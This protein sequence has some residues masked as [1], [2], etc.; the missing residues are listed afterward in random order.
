MMVEQDIVT[1]K[2][3]LAETLVHEI[4]LLVERVNGY[5][6]DIME[7]N[8]DRLDEQKQLVREVIDKIYNDMWQRYIKT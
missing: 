7:L 3:E 4:E 2:N 1:K 8:V 6:V 5:R